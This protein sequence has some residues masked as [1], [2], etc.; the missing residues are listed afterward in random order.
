MRLFIE[1]VHYLQ[2]SARLMSSDLS[3]EMVASCH[4]LMMSDWKMW[5]NKPKSCISYA[6]IP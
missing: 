5:V 6:M 1:R 2:G 3:V 4:M